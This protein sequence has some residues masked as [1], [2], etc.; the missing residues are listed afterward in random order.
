L[1]LSLQPHRFPI[2]QL[3]VAE[4]VVVMVEQVVALA[5]L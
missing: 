2:W 5:V 3:V 1:H 4:Q